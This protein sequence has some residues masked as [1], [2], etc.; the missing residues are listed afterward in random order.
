MPNNCNKPNSPNRKMLATIAYSVT[1]CP[2]SSSRLTVLFSLF[3][4]WQP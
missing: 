3:T 1:L 4:K 2:C